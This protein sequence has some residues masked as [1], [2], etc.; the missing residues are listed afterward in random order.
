MP[1]YPEQ[2]LR[3]DSH[4]SGSLTPHPDLSLSCMREWAIEPG[5]SKAELASPNP[6]KAQ[7]KFLTTSLKSE[8]ANPGTHFSGHER[9]FCPLYKDDKDVRR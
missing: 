7:A 4:S 5:Q 3:A 9:T 2:V 6:Q 8:Q 1:G